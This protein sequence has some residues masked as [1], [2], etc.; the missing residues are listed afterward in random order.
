MTI[1]KHD[2]G[3]MYQAQLFFF[4]LFFVLFS[5]TQWWAGVSPRLIRGSEERDLLHHAHLSLGATLFVLLV[6]FL[7]A[8]AVRPGASPIQKVKRAFATSGSTATSLFILSS[9]F[10][11][12]YGFGQA[13]S[14]G[15]ETAAFGVFNLPHF[16]NISWSTAGYMHSVFSSVTVYL[17][18]G[19][20]FVFLFRHLR[21]YMEPGYA[22]A[23]L[24]VVH[25]IVSLP[26][27]PSLHPI[28]A[29]GAYVLTPTIYLIALAIYC[30]AN[31]RRYVYWPIFIT[32][33]VL[34][35]YLPYF[36]F[37]VLPPWHQSPA[38]AAV[39]VEPAPGLVAARSKST[40]FE[41]EESLLEAQEIVLWCKQCHNL[42][43]DGPHLLGPN[44]DGVFNRQAGS[45]AGYDRYSTSMREHGEA[46]LFWS[47]ENLQEYLTDGQ[48]FVPNNLM[49]QQTDFSD[50]AKLSLALDYLEYVSADED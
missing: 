7:I 49:N 28:A 26:K 39:L 8:W 32:F 27:P 20:S 47:R 22:V 45:A 50:A 46:G 6:F 30:W 40:I 10:L 38:T 9:L 1:E 35:A 2:S 41:D 23:L 17:F 4:G 48:A 37:K 3:F 43:T 12:L 42:G 36:A 25:L 31:N 29:F 5:W 15:E 18:S 21:R 19:I 11:M 34:F 14:K 44:L 24:M 13:W 33:F 16:M